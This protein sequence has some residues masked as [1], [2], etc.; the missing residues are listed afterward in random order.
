M[1]TPPSPDDLSGTF[2]ARPSL[3]NHGI[4]VLTQVYRAVGAKVHPSCPGYDATVDHEAGAQRVRE[5]K[6]VLE[7]KFQGT[8]LLFGVKSY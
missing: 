7:D 5:L 8:A 2:A 3:T 4:T 1:F 6:L